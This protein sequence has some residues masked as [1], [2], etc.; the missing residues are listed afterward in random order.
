[1]SRVAAVRG[2]SAWY[3][4]RMSQLPLA[5]PMTLEEWADL[6]EDE[7]GELVDG[8]LVEEEEGGALHDVVVAWLI[9]VL[10]NWLA[11]RG[12]IVGASD[13]R[14]GV[15]ARRG[16]K[17]DLFAYL[18][19]R[20]PQAHGLVTTAPDIMVEVVSRRPRD[21]RRDR[22][23][24]LPEYAAF[25]VRFYWIVD[26][27]LRTVEILE[28][29]A[30]GRYAHATSV[31]EGCIDAVPGCDGLSL[32]VDALWGEVAKLEGDGPPHRS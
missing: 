9:R 3:P 19:G 15:A 1:M 16:R 12:G 13:V 18:P 22:V 27:G 14:F 8:Y 21:A 7:P 17:P 10:G 29:G 6:D 25:G 11:P 26:P 24:K 2:A 32:D 30:D 23:E 5:G 4:P 20:S 31:A 28:L